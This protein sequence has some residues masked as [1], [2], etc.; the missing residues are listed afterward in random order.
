[1]KKYHQDGPLLEQTEAEEKEVTTTR[2]T[3]ET[4]AKQSTMVKQATKARSK[5][6]GWHNS[7]GGK[8]NFGRASSNAT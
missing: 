8:V 3:D 6:D 1:M 7:V 4:S 2:Q 5:S